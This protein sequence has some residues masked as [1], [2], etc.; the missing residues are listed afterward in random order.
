VN[1]F[2]A[3]GSNLRHSDERTGGLNLPVTLGTFDGILL[4]YSG[5]RCLLEKWWRRREG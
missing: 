2:S 3:R 5:Q 4:R 1:G